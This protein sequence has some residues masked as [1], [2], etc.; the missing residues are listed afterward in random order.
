MAMKHKLEFISIC[1]FVFFLVSS[2]LPTANFHHECSG[3]VPQVDVPI[4]TPLFLPPRKHVCAT[5]IYIMLV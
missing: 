2:S 3:I 1:V 4:V 5:F